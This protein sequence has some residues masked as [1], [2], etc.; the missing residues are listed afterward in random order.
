MGADKLTGK[1]MKGTQLMFSLGNRYKINDVFCPL[2]LEWYFY[3][4]V[5]NFVQDT[6]NRGDKS[7][8]C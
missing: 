8:S 6:I 5:F 2:E 1:L 4:S 3:S 7:R